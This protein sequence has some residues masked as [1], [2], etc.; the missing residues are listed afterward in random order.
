ML[1]KIRIFIPQIKEK[2]L[3]TE[4]SPKEFVEKNIN[5]NFAFPIIIMKNFDCYQFN[6]DETFQKLKNLKLISFELPKFF[7]DINYNS[8]HFSIIKVYFEN[9]NIS[10]E[11]FS[12][13]YY[14]FLK[15]N[16]L[17]N[18]FKSSFFQK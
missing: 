2:I 3:S 18:N 4:P 9:C 13:I 12:E 17:E 7:N 15:N 14:S 1:E 8:N 16:K 5:L 6:F 10:T 11:S